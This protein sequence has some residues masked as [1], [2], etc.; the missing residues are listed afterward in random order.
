MI[1]SLPELLT[2][3]ETAQLLRIRVKTLHTWRG[4]GRGPRFIRIERH[5]IRYAVDD[6][7]S[8]L[9]LGTEP[10]REK[11]SPCDATS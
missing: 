5:M 4:Q 1:P 3:R 7:N 11:S 6:L 2:T 10:V 9:A 8:F